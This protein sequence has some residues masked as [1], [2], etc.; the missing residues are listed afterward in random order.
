MTRDKGKA[1]SKALTKGK[2]DASQKLFKV[3]DTLKLKVRASFEDNDYEPCELKVSSNDPSK[4]VITRIRTGDC[5]ILDN[6]IRR[7][8]RAR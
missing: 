4:L 7:L 5:V 2:N 1:A 8:R 3:S 6:Q